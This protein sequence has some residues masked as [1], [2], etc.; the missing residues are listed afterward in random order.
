MLIG[1]V[2]VSICVGCRVPLKKLKAMVAYPSCD[3]GWVSEKFGSES[4]RN[5]KKGLTCLRWVFDGG[6]Q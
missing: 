5:E 6:S 2:R 3:L 1:C 4:I